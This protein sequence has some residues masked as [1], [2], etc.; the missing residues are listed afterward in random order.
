MNAEDTINDLTTMAQRIRIASMIA[1]HQAGSGH[2]SSSMSCA[3]L[4]AALFFHCM[5][6][7]IKDPDMPGND[8]FILSKGHAAPALWAALA[9]AGAITHDALYSLRQIDSV[10]EGHPTPRSQ[11][12]DVPSGSLGQGLSMG[13]GMALWSRMQ[14][15]DNH[16]WV[17]L[18]DGECAE[19]AVWEAAMLSDHYECKRLTAIVD[20]NRLGQCG[21]TMHGHDC[22]VYQQRFEAFGWD[23]LIIDGHDMH[24]IVTALEHARHSDKPCA[25]IAQTIKGK[26]VSFL[27]DAEGRHGK[28]LDGAEYQAALAELGQPGPLPTVTM[29]KPQQY[30]QL[31]RRQ[32][33]DKLPDPCFTEDT[34]TRHAYGTALATLLPYDDRLLVFDAEVS[35][36]TGAEK[37]RQANADRFIECFIAEQ[38][39]LGMALGA[40]AIGAI[41]CV[42]TFAAFLTRA[43]DQLRMAGIAGH[44]LIVAGSH[45]GVSIGEDGPS[46]MGLE[47]MALMRSIPGSRVL[48]PSDAVSCYRLLATMINETGLCYLRTARPK[49]PLLYQLHD[50]EFSIGGSRLLRYSD[51]DAVTVLAC[52]VCVHE[53]L[54]AAERLAD[55]DIQLRV[56]DAYSIKPLD[57]QNI[58]AAAADTGALIT[59]EDHY[60]PGGLGECVAA[61]VLPHLTNC[62]FKQLAV[63]DLPRS[64]DSGAL[65]ARHAIDADAIVASVYQSLETV[66]V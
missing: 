22:S 25:I 64:G 10:I 34:A 61:E 65:L 35:N 38:N 1:T 60:A 21:V 51:D 7:D 36:S 46:Q 63:H 9:E 19:G 33:G 40:A 57:V 55:K 24:S 47:D 52:G 41:P 49:L 62:S 58:A 18:G 23:S 28:V 4:L 6:Y 2:P 54:Q 56:I 39:M 59:V 31:N 15:I 44:H 13:L 16:V 17:M 42:S 66:S 43:A 3:D 53:A 12:V 50:H 14:G 11:F 20:V 27:E 37:A 30:L 32:F 29:H 45:S 48:C 8:R 5:R 26:G